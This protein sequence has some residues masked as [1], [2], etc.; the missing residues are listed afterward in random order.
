MIADPSGMPRR[1]KV[2]NQRTMT[3]EEVVQI[4]TTE[5]SSVSSRIHR[6]P[7]PLSR[8]ALQKNLRD[9]RNVLDHY[10]IDSLPVLCGPDH[11]LDWT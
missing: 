1:L 10:Q 11:G 9:P 4:F 7:A 5:I 6:I 3:S 2:Q 8:I